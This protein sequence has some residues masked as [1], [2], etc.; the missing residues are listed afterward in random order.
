MAPALNVR[1][2]DSTAQTIRA[3][4]LAKATTAVFT[5][6]RARRPRSPRP[7]RRRA[8]GQGAQD[9]ARTM[10]QELAKVFVPA[11]ADAQQLGSPAGARL[12]RHQP[13]PGGKVPPSSER[14]ARP[15]RCEQG[16]C[17]Q[18]PN[19]GDGGQTTCSL[20]AASTSSELVIEC[21]NAPVALA[22]LGPHVLNQHPHP[23]AERNL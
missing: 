19:A 8:P 1:V 11:L 9:G 21:P 7:E 15:D 14:L 17:V 6:A 13:E 10:D 22:P 20:I 3:S 16:R 23:R 4:L 2:R 12:P 18:H 5:C